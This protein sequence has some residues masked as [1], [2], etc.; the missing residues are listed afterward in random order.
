MVTI[1]KEYVFGV[2]EVRLPSNNTP[3]PNKQL[4]LYNLTTMRTC[5]WIDLDLSRPE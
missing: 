5:R 2:R 1:E 3:G 4:A